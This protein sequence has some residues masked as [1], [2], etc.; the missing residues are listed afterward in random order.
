MDSSME[1][2]YGSGA[3]IPEG[4]DSGRQRESGMGS[5][6]DVQNPSQQNVDVGDGIETHGVNTELTAARSQEQEAAAILEAANGLE[7]EYE[8]QSVEGGE[9][10]LQGQAGDEGTLDGLGSFRQEPV[11]DQRGDVR[12][13]VVD[14]QT[15]G[16]LNGVIRGGRNAQLLDVVAQGGFDHAAGQSQGPL[17]W[18]RGS[19]GD[20]RLDVLESLVQQ[21]FQ[22]NE[23][24]K[25]ELSDQASR[26]VQRPSAFP[27]EGTLQVGL[28][29][30]LA[31]LRVAQL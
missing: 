30:Q 2:S 5:A 9:G 19:S 1:P 27:K 24:L 28:E 12:Q 22:Q 16:L 17:D 14:T 10:V 7:P 18:D 20:G 21:L 25:Q 3:A 8:F 26:S 4:S 23:Y 11:F 15:G 13:P 6:A 31:L 29:C